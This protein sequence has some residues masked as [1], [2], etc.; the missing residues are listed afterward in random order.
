[1]N[2]LVYF[3]SEIVTGSCNIIDDIL[4]WSNNMPT[5]LLMYECI[6][7]VYMK[8]RVSLKIKKCSFFKDRFEY[9][10]RDIMSLGNTTAQSKYDFIKRWSRPSIGEQLHSFVSFCNFYS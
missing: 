1:M 10:G 7:K 6:C 5:L 3:L 9:V 8:Y 2:I 4:L